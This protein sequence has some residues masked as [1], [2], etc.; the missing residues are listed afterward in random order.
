MAPS[1]QTALHTHIT[2]HE[3]DYKTPA[4]PQ[5]VFFT[6]ERAM[7][8]FR[9]MSIDEGITRKYY[10]QKC[11]HIN[12]SFKIV[13]S[14]CLTVII[15]NVSPT[16]DWENKKCYSCSK[17]V[18]KYKWLRLIFV[19][20]IFYFKLW[21]TL[22][23][24]PFSIGILKSLHLKTGYST[25]SCST[26]LIFLLKLWTSNGLFLVLILLDLPIDLLPDT[27]GN[28]LLFFVQEH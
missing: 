21:V 6:E 2:L 20:K 11:D 8:S 4:V 15:Y 22:L 5:P 1:L 9:W 7:G 23:F 25:L 12:S 28:V 13:T 16:Q 18:W 3:R 27:P 10:V 17:L 19:I 14:Q 24:I 26:A